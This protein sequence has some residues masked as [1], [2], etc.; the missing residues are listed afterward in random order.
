[1]REPLV[2]TNNELI[3]KRRKKRTIKRTIILA[4]LII[5]ILVTLCLKL[6]YFNVTSVKIY[7][8]RIVTS[9][10]ISELAKV[11]IG[12]N[13]FYININNIRTNVLNNPYILK[14]EVKRK[15]P[16]TVVISISERQAVFYGKFDNKYLI[17]DKDGIILEERDDVSKMRLTNLEGFNYDEAKLGETIPSEDKTKINNIGIITELIELNSSGIEITSV[18]LSDGLNTIVSC[19]N[20]LIKLGRNNIKD[21][22]NLALNIIL[23]NNL[24]NQK[25]YIDVSFEGNPVVNMDE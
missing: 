15:L 19:S 20:I 24:K 13:I 6:N 22:L 12:T 14:A 10:E 2:N 9:D 25:G 11:R 8:N 3:E 4:V 5:A 21:R 23:N 16:N 7:N 18:N 17:I 1:M